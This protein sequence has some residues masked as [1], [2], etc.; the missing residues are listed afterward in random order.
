M[1]LAD[2]GVNFSAAAIAVVTALVGALAGAVTFLFRLYVASRDSQLNDLREQRDA[3][4]KVADRA[5]ETLEKEAGRRQAARG[6]VPVPMLAPVVPEHNSPTTE[7]QQAA[8]DL[9]TIKAREVAAR[10][11]LEGPV[12]PPEGPP[13]P[14]VKVV[15]ITP[16][17]VEAIVAALPAVPPRET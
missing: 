11:I 2:N 8:A 13:L 14:A 5:V 12:L 1:L 4:K 10:L 15:E 9:E 17:V 7:H 6:E 16:E 3:F